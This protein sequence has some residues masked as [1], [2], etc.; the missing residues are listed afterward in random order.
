[1]YFRIRLRYNA[2]QAMQWVR[3]FHR[4]QF[5]VGCILLRWRPRSFLS[6]LHL[7]KKW[8]D[9]DQTHI[10]I[11]GRGR[12]VI[13]FWW[14]WPHFQGHTGT[15]KF[16]NFDQKS[17]SAHYLLNQVTDSGQ[18]SGIVMLGWFKHLFWFW[19]SWP[20]FQS[21]HTIKTLQISNFDPKKHVYTLSLEPNDRFWPNFMFCNLGMV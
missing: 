11:I 6:A 16:S 8:V 13:R 14:H 20:N 21:H 19:W 18:T 3:G 2:F 17:L 7:L 4:L 1:M 12:E 9:F 15:L 5:R 10:R